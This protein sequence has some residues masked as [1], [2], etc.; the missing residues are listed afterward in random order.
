MTNDVITLGI[1]GYIEKDHRLK[2]VL[3]GGKYQLLWV[4]GPGEGGE[5]IKKLISQPPAILVV[6]PYRAG[7]LDEMYR[8]VLPPFT[9]VVERAHPFGV[10]SINEPLA[11]AA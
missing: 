3:A 5:A 4:C 9:T 1:F 8:K 2:R 7:E 11:I 6:N 10:S